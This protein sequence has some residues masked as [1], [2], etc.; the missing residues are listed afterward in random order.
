MNYPRLPAIVTPRAKGKLLAQ[1]D[2]YNQQ[3][4]GLGDRF[5]DE[6]LEAV[7]Y[8]EV[9]YQVPPLDQGNPNVRRYV[10]RGHFPWLVYYK[11]ANDHVVVSLFAH[12]KER[13][14]RLNL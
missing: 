5:Y 3:L 6:I 2:W 8:L 12:P 4:D 14:V 1:R 9:N 11:I 10:S 13:P 7:S